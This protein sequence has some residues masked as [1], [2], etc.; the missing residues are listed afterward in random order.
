MSTFQLQ[1][2]IWI[3]KI[4]WLLG[5]QKTVF[6]Q[7]WTFPSIG[8]FRN[9]YGRLSWGGS[10]VWSEWSNGWKP[11]KRKRQLE[12]FNKVKCFRGSFSAT[13]NYL[14]SRTRNWVYT[15]SRI[16]LSYYLALRILRKRLCI[17]KNIM[18]PRWAGVRDY[19]QTLRKY[20]QMGGVLGVI[21]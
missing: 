4:I 5:H 15:S 7:S 9:D 1:G 2:V 13:A 8:L 12:Q 19:Y 14:T 21:A 16:G 17:G 11:W 18:M 10:L 6:A 3:G 20:R